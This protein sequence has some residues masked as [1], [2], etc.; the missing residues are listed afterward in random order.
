MKYPSSV[1]V[2]VDEQGPFPLLRS[3]VDEWYVTHKTKN[4]WEDGD[5]ALK[6]VEICLHNVIDVWNQWAFKQIEEGNLLLACPLLNPHPYIA[7]LAIMTHDRA[8]IHHEKLVITVHKR[9]VVLH[10]IPAP[11]HDT[12]LLIVPV[13]EVHNVIPIMP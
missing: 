7:A 8:E 1:P 2:N 12:L 6:H 9:D 13:R 10:C 5:D 4:L 11:P 3:V